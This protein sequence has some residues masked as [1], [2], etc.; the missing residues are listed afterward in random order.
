MFTPPSEDIEIAGARIYF[1]ISMPLQELPITESQVNSWLVIIAVFFLCLFMTHGL[2]ATQPTRRQHIL[3][4]IVEATEN[5]V[6]DNM[7]EYFKDFAP[8]VGAIMGKASATP[9]RSSLRS[10]LSARLQRLSQWLS[11]TT[12]TCFPVR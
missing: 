8:F 1:T 12:E 3:E 4:M 7:G 2:S 6:M 11:V 9:F 10:M 5:L